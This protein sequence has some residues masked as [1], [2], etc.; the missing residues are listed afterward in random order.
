MKQLFVDDHGVQEINNLARKL[1]P[2]QRFHA[3][4]VVRPENRWENE[5]IQIRTTPSYNP[6]DG[7]FRM[8]YKAASEGADVGLAR[9]GRGQSFTCYATSE[10][11]INWDKPNLGIYDYSGLTW[12]GTPIGSG[13]GE[14]GARSR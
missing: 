11:A 2:L 9:T 6:E 10:D 3:N 12:R 5:A 8:T 14:R 4:A 13:G 1:H 7:L